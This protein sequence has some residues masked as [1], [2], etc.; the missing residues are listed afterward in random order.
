MHTDEPLS[1]PTPKDPEIKRLL[2][3]IAFKDALAKLVAE[4]K[5]SQTNLQRLEVPGLGPGQ[6]LDIHRRYHQRESE[7]AQ[8]RIEIFKLPRE[9]EEL[10]R[11]WEWTCTPGARLQHK[12]RCMMLEAGRSLGRSRE[13]TLPEPPELEAKRKLNS[14]M[15]ALESK[16]KHLQE[17]TV[18]D[19]EWNALIHATP[20]PRRL[21]TQAPPPPKAVGGNWIAREPKPTELPTSFPP[22]FPTS[23]ALKAR[24]ILADVVREFPD[25]SNVK[26]LCK[27]LV[28]RYTELLCTG[29]RS[30]VLKAH[31]APNEVNT[32]ID[33]VL[34]AN[35]AREHERFEI[36]RAV[37]N[38]DEWHAMLAQLLEC[39]SDAHPTDAKPADLAKA[40][41]PTRQRIDAFL[42]T[43]RQHGHRVSRKDIWRV[44]GYED[45]TEFQRFQREDSRATAG[46]R[47]Q[48]DRILSLRPDEFIQ[49][50]HKVRSK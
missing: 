41:S 13:T 29:V 28:S 42:Q 24:V 23:L 33:H 19:D 45:A 43:M 48:F 49:K 14:A 37:I 40:I 25:R 36:Q 46:S 32:T 35:C 21:V 47:Q 38:S 30:G 15:A 3:E 22:G 12:R 5:S 39:E 8:L 6:A 50:L 44:A 9:I 1:T 27:E 18:N 7:K 17:I 10:E 11:R 34:V 31:E 20:A 16:K 26:R 4:A 2:S